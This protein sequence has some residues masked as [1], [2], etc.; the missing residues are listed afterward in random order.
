[1]GAVEA[2]EQVLQSNGL[3]DAPITRLDHPMVK[4]AEQFTHNFE[5]IAERKSVIHHLRELAK[6]SIIAK[7]LLDACI[8]LEESWFELPCENHIPCSLEVPQLWNERINLE[9]ELKD[10]K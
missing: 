6:A 10:G 7:Y 3:R 8:N 9:V 4:Y 1:M 2:R 5:L